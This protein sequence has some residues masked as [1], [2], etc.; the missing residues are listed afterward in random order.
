MGRVAEARSHAE[1][2]EHYFKHAGIAGYSQAE[3]HWGE[4]QS[5]LAAAARSSKKQGD[6]SVIQAIIQ[7]SAPQMAEMKKR[8]NESPDNP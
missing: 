3:Y 6:A 5:L 1:R 7:A 2:I 4:L 8:S